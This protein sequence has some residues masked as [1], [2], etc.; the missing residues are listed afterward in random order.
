MKAPIQSIKLS[1]SAANQLASLKKKTGIRNWN[2]LCRWAFCVSLAE[3]SRPPD[4]EHPSDSSVEMSWRVFGGE[5]A[6]VYV[7]LLKQRAH[8]DGCQLD[9]ESLAYQLRLHLHRG[10]SYLAA[11]KTLR[12]GGIGAL[13]RL[14]PLED[15]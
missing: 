13:L 7:A 4:A 1:Q 15:G 8:V 5:F 2:T 10:L 14:A 11:D 3:P 6:D 12:T 9:D